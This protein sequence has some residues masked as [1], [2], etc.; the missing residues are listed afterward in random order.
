MS[1]RYPAPHI[2]LL[3]LASCLGLHVVTNDRNYE[4]RAEWV[5][6][7]YP[8]AGAFRD[9]SGAAVTCLELSDEGIVLHHNG[10]SAIAKVLV[11][12]HGPKAIAEAV[13]AWERIQ[14]G[15]KAA[16]RPVTP[17]PVGA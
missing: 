1:S 13:W 9:T 8:H 4:R 7:A 2:M 11:Q 3:R 10:D 5:F 15:A 17:D 6:G 12:G 16:Q 14:D